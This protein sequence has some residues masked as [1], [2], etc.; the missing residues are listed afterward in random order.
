MKKLALTMLLCTLAASSF[1][2]KGKILCLYGS[3]TTSFS[4]E[5]DSK[6]FK[7]GKIIDLEG[8][9]V[10]STLLT[11]A[12]MKALF[13]KCKDKKSVKG[14]EVLV[15]NAKNDN[16]YYHL[17]IQNSLNELIKLNPVWSGATKDSVTVPLFKHM[18]REEDVISLKDFLQN[19]GG[20]VMIK[21]GS[22]NINLLDVIE[23]AN[24][25]N[26]TVLQTLYAKITTNLPRNIPPNEIKAT[27][28]FIL[29]YSGSEGLLSS[30]QA[31]LYN[32]LQIQHFIR[33]LHGNK[34]EISDSLEFTLQPT[35]SK[36]L[37]VNAKI[38][39]T[40]T[41]VKWRNGRTFDDPINTQ[42]N[43]AMMSSQTFIVDGSKYKLNILVTQPLTIKASDHGF[44]NMEVIG[45]GPQDKSELIQAIKMG[46]IAP[47]VDSLREFSRANEKFNK[48][49]WSFT[50]KDSLKS[51]TPG[52][53]ISFW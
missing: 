39:Q 51:N 49:K 50:I 29:K 1:A 17:Y 33:P 38:I 5:K 53:N 3:S 21:I 12:D 46:L 10:F 47:N 27:A 40:F 31:P 15:T 23:S 28:D 13:T 24:K 7:E 32:T 6:L 14:Y 42:E 9:R 44:N 37:K 18:T 52:S 26:N 45:I 4:E 48:D 30:M 34:K 25:S 19:Q 22:A 16:N 35:S 11:S 2:T 36:T 43:F 20:N 8:Q 41:G